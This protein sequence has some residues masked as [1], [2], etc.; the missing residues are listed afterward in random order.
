MINIECIVKLV[1]NSVL[2][3]TISHLKSGTHANNKRRRQQ[4]LSLKEM[5]ITN[6]TDYD[7][8][9]DDCNNT[10]SFNC[11]I[12]ENNNDNFIPTLFLTIPCGL[13]F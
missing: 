8:V 5:Y 6:V 12:K 4:S 10:L 7:N 11:K 2:K 3:N 9:T 13:S 1:I